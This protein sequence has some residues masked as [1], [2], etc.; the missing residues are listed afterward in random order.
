MRALSIRA[1]WLSFSLTL[2]LGAA[3]RT[4]G[5][6][7]KDK[8][9]D[10]DNPQSP[11]EVYEWSIWVG[12]PA[13]TTLNTTRV[14]KNAMPNS[15]GTSRPKFED[16]DLGKKF[17]VAPVSVVQFFGE[18][19][20]DIDVDLRTKKGLFLSH[21]PASTER[22]GRL[23]WFK[24]DFSS[25]PPA[26]IPQSYLPGEH[27][28][29]QLR[30]NNSALF[31]KHESHYERFIAYDAELSLPIPVRIRGGPDEYT[32]QNLTG[33]RLLDVA[34]IAVADNGYRVGWL[35]E[36]PSA[37]PE[38]KEDSTGKPDEPAPKKGEAATKKEPAAGK[39]EEAAAKKKPAPTADEV[40]KEAETKK[41]AEE[42]AIPPMPAEGD[43]D[44]RGRVDQLLNRPITVTV[45][46]MPRRQV[47]ELVM[48]Q[49]RLRYELDDKTLAKE[50]VDLTQPMDMNANRI[51]ARDALADV[52]GGAS[53]SYRI[54]ENGSLYITTA[55]RLA[56]DVGKKGKVIEGPPVK[57]VMSQPRKP[58]DA[59]Y[60][61][62]TRDALARR[63][64]GQ[65]LRE[66][67]VK[68]LLAEYGQALFEPKEL[69]VLVHLSRPAIDEGVPLDVFPP[70]KK[71]VRTALVVVH[72]V[73][74]RLQDRARTLV[75]KLGD[76]SPKERE[77][78]EARL[79]E[80]GP[81]AVPVLE[82]ALKNKDVEIVFRAERLLLK[83]NRQVP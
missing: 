13:Q 43:A 53:L 9:K 68:V 22:A 38:K 47:L 1:L 27:W 57:L 36:L 60:R 6:D 10:K 67:V 34:V 52:L 69:V 37:T 29:Q 7:D 4:S 54:T 24:S 71:I 56:E 40:F 16:K 48:G 32:L 64:A 30:Q 63:L 45:H 62:L 55:A 35:D 17:P 74:P 72:G 2:V 66:D 78:A 11:I 41:K 75:Q 49:A 61:E 50:K 70:P 82:D 31:L 3:F 18:P 26:N 65:G 51:A 33:F 28:T 21:W 23:Q 76:Q 73:D 15:V 44:V 5:F 42:E 59:S 20:K 19:H 83:L 58:S 81:V 12:N 79:S 77:S 25:D 14:Y 8:I 46:Q 39:K 80:M